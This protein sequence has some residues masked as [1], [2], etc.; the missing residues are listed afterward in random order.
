MED[1]EDG[2]SVL[3]IHQTT[4]CHSPEDSHLRSYCYENLRS[5][6]LHF[7][8][9]VGC[10]CF[11]CLVIACKVFAIWTKQKKIFTVQK[12]FWPRAGVCN[13][14]SSV[15][16]LEC[17]KS[18]KNFQ[19]WQFRVQTVHVWIS[20]IVFLLSTF[21]LCMFAYIVICIY[22]FRWNK[23]FMYMFVKRLS[24]WDYATY[25]FFVNFYCGF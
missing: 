7:F 14:D 9:L 10:Q 18:S 25:Y 5:Q 2:G 4:L 20:Y 17:G 12:S 22:I 16:V 15:E 6:I 23:C 13:A 3:P 8:R 11:P 21:E 19:L 24:V 1:P